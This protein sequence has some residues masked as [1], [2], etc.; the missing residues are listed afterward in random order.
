MKKKT[1]VAF[2]VLSLVLSLFILIRL[3]FVKNVRS[4]ESYILASLI[5]ITAV[6][7]LYLAYKGLIQRFRKNHVDHAKY[8]V[9]FDLEKTTVTGELEFYFTLDESKNIS[10]QIL[11]SQMQPI[12]IV[13]D[14]FYSVGGHIVRYNTNKLSNGYYFYCL[15]TENQKTMKRMLVQHDNLTA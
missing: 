6:G 4:W 3:Y 15:I 11:D 14:A 5:G 2:L 10:F 8:A 7:M 13:N 1:I 12:E 9:L